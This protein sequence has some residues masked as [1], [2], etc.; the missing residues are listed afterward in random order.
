M[1]IP[2]PTPWS[3]AGNREIADAV[4]NV[5]QY[6]HANIGLICL[7][8]NQNER[9]SA[10]L[11]EIENWFHADPEDRKS[12]TEILG[13]LASATGRVGYEVLA[14]QIEELKQADPEFDRRMSGELQVPQGSY[15]SSIDMAMT[16]IPEG[17]TFTI[18]QGSRIDPVTAETVSLPK[19]EMKA[20]DGRI[21]GGLGSTIP[22]AA[23]AAALRAR[24]LD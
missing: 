11:A 2:Q 20:P 21:V 23:C 17:W 18:S 1:L 3:P 10:V 22:L 4:G 19:A 9:M 8:I 12:E 13:L 15:T 16:L 6:T 7:A 14:L 5:V 24:D